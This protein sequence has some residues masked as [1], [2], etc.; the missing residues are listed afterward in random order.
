MT[1]M[2]KSTRKWCWKGSDWWMS[3][4]VMRVQDLIC[5]DQIQILFN[6]FILQ[7]RKCGRIQLCS[8]VRVLHA[9]KPHMSRFWDVGAESIRF[10]QAKQVPASSPQIHQTY[11]TSGMFFENK[12]SSLMCL[13]YMYLMTYSNLLFV[14]AHSFVEVKAAWVDPRWSETREHHVGRPCETTLQGKSHRLWVGISRQ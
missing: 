13:C 9:Q 4:N 2:W 5:R 7:P 8:S 14:G 11:H 12:F 1:M 3:S 6:F 10:P